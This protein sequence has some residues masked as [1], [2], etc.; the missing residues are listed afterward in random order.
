MLNNFDLAKWFH[1]RAPLG[2]L[3]LG[4]AVLL[5]LNLVAAYFLFR[6]IGGSP[7]ELREE[8]ATKRIQLHQGRMLEENTKSMSEKVQTGRNEGTQFLKAYFLERRSAYRL[9]L[10]ELDAAAKE[11]GIQSRES[12]FTLEPVEGSDRLEMMKITAN[13]QGTY[14][15]LI[16]FINRLDKSDQLLIIEGLQATPMQQATT[17]TIS[18][19]LDAFVRQDAETMLVGGAP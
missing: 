10:S 16:H 12:S 14:S 13:Y 7:E 8:L 2:L 5:L 18:M 19:K 3:R 6:P 11:S 1:P 17:L 15:N 9:V 4:A